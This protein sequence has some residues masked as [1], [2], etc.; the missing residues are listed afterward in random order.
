MGDS[1]RVPGR[2]GGRDRTAK[3][4]CPQ[5]RIAQPDKNVTAGRPCIPSSRTNEAIATGILP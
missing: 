3:D 1:K 4:K 5:R 2:Y